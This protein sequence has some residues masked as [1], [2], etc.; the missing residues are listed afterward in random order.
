ML[1]LTCLSRPHNST[2]LPANAGFDCIVPYRQLQSYRGR[3]R[4]R[5]RQLWHVLSSSTNPK[6]TGLRQP[7]KIGFAGYPSISEL[8]QP[9][10]NFPCRRSDIGENI[11]PSQYVTGQFGKN[12]LG[13]RN[14]CLPTSSDFS[15]FSAISHLN[16]EEHSDDSPVDPRFHERFGPHG[17]LGTD[18][19]EGADQPSW[20]PQ[21]TEGTRRFPASKWRHVGLHSHSRQVSCHVTVMYSGD[22]SVGA[23]LSH[24]R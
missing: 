14:F 22:I 7:S 16:A 17:V 8:K 24:Q 10:Q 6:T 18:K 21:K 11:E 20:E 12:P 13:D 2:L 23:I 15:S 19:D 9:R 4:Y 5:N 1:R 3:P